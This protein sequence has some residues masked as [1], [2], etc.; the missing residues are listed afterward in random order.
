[1]LGLLIGVLL[2]CLLSMAMAYMSHKKAWEIGVELECLKDE[3][4]KL[5][6]AKGKAAKGGKKC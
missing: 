2:A 6:A 4:E 1:M 3:I 5:K